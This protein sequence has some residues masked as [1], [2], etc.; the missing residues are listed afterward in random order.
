M[1]EGAAPA[2]VSESLWFELGNKK[3]SDFFFHFRFDIIITQ[4]EVTMKP[5]KFRKSLRLHK[6][7]IANLE[8]IQ[9]QNVAGGL[10]TQFYPCPTVAYGSCGTYCNTYPN[11]YPCPHRICE[12]VDGCGVTDFC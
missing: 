2:F 3:N 9:M 7:T 4:M 1:F 10:A 5:I 11:R 8:S 6:T 12:T